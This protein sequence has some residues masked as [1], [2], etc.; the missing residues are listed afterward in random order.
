MAVTRKCRR[1][2]STAKSPADDGLGPL[3][4]KGDKVHLPCRALRSAGCLR[5]YLPAALITL[6]LLFIDK[7]YFK[8]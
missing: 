2:L 7:T 6:D 4:P 8:I 3:G 1:N 5:I